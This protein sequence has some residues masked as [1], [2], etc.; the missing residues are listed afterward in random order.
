MKASVIHQYGGPDVLT[1]ED[2]ADPIV[3]D[4]QVLVRV[5]ATSINPVDI[6]R[7]SG[8]MKEIFPVKFPGILGVDVAGT[9]V[10]LGAGVEGFVVG[11]RVFAMGQET[12]AEYCAVTAANLARIP[13]GLDPVEAAALPLVTTTGNLLIAQGTDVKAG[14]TVLIT[15]AAGSVGRSAVFT[16]KQRGAVVI[17]G[18]RGRQ[19]EEAATLG[20]DRV[21]ATDDDRALAQL[22]PVDAVAD[23]VG[24]KTAAALLDKV[25]AGGAFA[26]VLG[27]PANAKDY[28]SVRVVPVY[29][30]PNAR[31]LAQMARAVVEG[32]LT[33]PISRKLPLSGA[34]EGHAAVEKGGLGKVLLMA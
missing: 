29:S 22:A 14:Q 21:V 6:G 8:R 2:Y 23:A 3:G 24:G 12:Y 18:V 28:P 9:I 13:E 26:S 4:G 5:A 32:K 10:K 1:F 31:T 25:R 34:A 30:R 15:G 7:R 27:A 19:S 17:A 16:A 11:D 33:I 20:A